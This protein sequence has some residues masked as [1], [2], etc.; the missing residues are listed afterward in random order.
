M[1]VKSQKRK[2]DNIIK[3]MKQ[4]RNIIFAVEN[5]EEGD[6]FI[7]S[8]LY[9]ARK[10][11]SMQLSKHKLERVFIHNHTHD[12]I[13]WG[14]LNRRPISEFKSLM[15]KRYLRSYINHVYLCNLSIECSRLVLPL[16]KPVYVFD[17]VILP[18]IK[19]VAERYF[20]RRD[21]VDKRYY[22]LDLIVYYLENEIIFSRTNEIDSFQPI[23][24]DNEVDCENEMN[25]VSTSGI[26]VNKVYDTHVE[27][28]PHL[29]NITSLVKELYIDYGLNVEDSYK[30]IIDLYRRGYITNPFTDSKHLPV[31]LVDHVLSLLERHLE[32]E[33]L[34]KYKLVIPLDTES[35]LNS[36]MFDFDKK[37]EYHAIIPT[38]RSTTI[39]LSEIQ[40]QILTIITNRLFEVLLP[41]Y[42]SHTVK[43]VVE[44]SDNQYFVATSHTPYNLGWKSIRLN[45][46]RVHFTNFDSIKYDESFDYIEKLEIGDEISFDLVHVTGH[47]TKPPDAYNYGE[48]IELGVEDDFGIGSPNHRFTEHSRLVRK[49]WIRNMPEGAVPTKKAILA[50]KSLQDVKLISLKELIKYERALLECNDDEIMIQFKNYIDFIKGELHK[51]REKES[52]IYTDMY[53]Y[54]ILPKTEDISYDKTVADIECPGCSSTT[55]RRGLT[56]IFCSAPK[57]NFVM[58]IRIDNID[59]TS[60]DIRKLFLEKKAK[61]I[62]G[63]E[64]KNVILTPDYKIRVINE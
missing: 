24:Y 55:L 4:S 47:S 51:I 22:T 62:I 36:K 49:K 29:F 60:A 26:I 33:E 21:F 59:I 27:P 37:D 8:I 54:Y 43:V 52:H 6:N 63:E 64:E 45:D 13:I 32:N 30:A 44:C 2:I 31:E 38:K 9:Y 28:S 15:I 61:V 5:S 56:T 40:V 39:D 41:D 17:R 7:T 16:K 1:P 3:L 23:K 53:M 12:S 20:E 48:I 46:S 10:N 35:L 25:N 57:C 42:V 50:I 34:S 11:H 58:D 19:D 14:I 18:S